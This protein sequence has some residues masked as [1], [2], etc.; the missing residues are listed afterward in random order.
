MIQR[1]CIAVLVSAAAIVAGCIMPTSNV[2][3]SP[4]A[5]MS[6]VKTVAVWQF[7]DGGKVSNSGAI[8]T[9]SLEGAL[10]T[11]GWRLIPFSRM[12]DVLAVEIGYR[13]GMALDAGML[14][15]AVLTR[16]KGEV[17]A[18]AILLGSVSDAW[19]NVMYAPSCWME[20]AFQLISTVDGSLMVSGNVSDDGWSVQ[21]AATQM[22]NKAVSQLR[23]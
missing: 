12:R 1:A 6:Q 10:M 11:K 16:L 5:S 20:C 3:T 15:P 19:C 23:R 8:A 17:G 22:A 13:D 18:D 2:V 9:R 4:E 7:Q 21:A 14:T